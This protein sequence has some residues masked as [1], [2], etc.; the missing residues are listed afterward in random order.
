MR[1]PVTEPNNPTAMYGGQKPS[2]TSLAMAAATMSQLNT[3]KQKLNAAASS[4]IPGPSA[5]A[6]KRG[7]LKATPPR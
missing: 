4:G 3:T 7:G 1:V 6:P 2:E 5:A